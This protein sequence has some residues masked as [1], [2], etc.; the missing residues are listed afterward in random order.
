MNQIASVTLAML[1]PNTVVPNPA[2]ANIIGQ[3]E[4]SGFI[5]KD[6]LRLNQF[7]DPKVEG[8]SLY[9]AD[10][11]RPITDKLKKDFFNDPSSTSLTCAKSGGPI[12]LADN[13]V[14]GSSGEE[15]FEESRNLFF[16]VRNGIWNESDEMSEMFLFSIYTY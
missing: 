3:F 16:K 5:F 14:K 12:V 2:N 11:E 10:F 1:L 7:N 15:V 9:L 8:V 4:T 6:T 13:L